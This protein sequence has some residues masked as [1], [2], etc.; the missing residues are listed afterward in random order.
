MRS[1][2]MITF[3]EGNKVFLRVLEQS[4][5]LSTGKAPKLLLTYCR[6]FTILKRVGSVAYKLALP[7]SSQV[8]LVFHISHSRKQLYEQDQVID[9]SV[10][11]EYEEP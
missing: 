4:Q 8:H 7:E 3:E 9:F 10:L 11:V 2:E 1:V 6:P 5:T